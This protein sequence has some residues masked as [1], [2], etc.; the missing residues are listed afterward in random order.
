MKGVSLVFAPLTIHQF[1]SRTKLDLFAIHEDNHDDFSC[2]VHNSVQT[3]EFGANVLIKLSDL[4]IFR[5]YASIN[6]RPC[7]H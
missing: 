2:L 1:A 6:G 4:G 3:L 5:A 7:A